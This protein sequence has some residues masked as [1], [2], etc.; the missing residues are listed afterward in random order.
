MKTWKFQIIALVGAGIMSITF[1]VISVV[2]QR[3]L[4]RQQTEALCQQL[5]ADVI[6]KE[7]KIVEKALTELEEVKEKIKENTDKK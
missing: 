3:Q 1:G 6:A 2:Q 5:H 7:N 4:M